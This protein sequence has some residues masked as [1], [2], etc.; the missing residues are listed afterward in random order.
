MQRKRNIL[1]ILHVI[2]IRLLTFKHEN[3][4]RKT[5][6]LMSIIYRNLNTEL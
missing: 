6:I 2:I 3:S 1:D 5:E 4:M